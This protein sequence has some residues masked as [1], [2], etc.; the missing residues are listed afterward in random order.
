MINITIM[1]FYGSLWRLCEEEN[2]KTVLARVDKWSDAVG[3]RHRGNWSY[4]SVNCVS[5]RSGVNSVGKGGSMN[6][7]SKGSGM[8]SM[9]GERSV[10]GM[11]TM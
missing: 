11:N 7:M 6:S 10:D 2:V 5:Q 1:A 8:N 4:R 3:E 9:V